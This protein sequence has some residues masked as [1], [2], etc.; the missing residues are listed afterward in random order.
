VSSK[1]KKSNKRPRIRVENEEE[2]RELTTILAALRFWQQNVLDRGLDPRKVSPFHFEGP[3]APLDSEE[4]NE[5]CEK[6]N[7]GE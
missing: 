2:E 3:L 7:F 5:V 4:V 6:L 1:T